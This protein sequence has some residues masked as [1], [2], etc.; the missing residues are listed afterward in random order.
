MNLFKKESSISQMAN[1]AIVSIKA[2][3]VYA[4]LLVISMLIAVLSR[5]LDQITVSETIS[6]PSLATYDQLQA[7]YPSTLSCSC[8]QVAVA[9][10]TFVS[11]KPR[12]HQVS[13][14]T[15]LCQLQLCCNLKEQTLELNIFTNFQSM[16][17]NVSQM[18]I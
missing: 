7:K 13:Y 17:E 2:S 1:V 12:I 9:F 6:F 11:L 16:L 18:T 14:S 5:S 10:K 4:V 8:Q 3:R 15:T